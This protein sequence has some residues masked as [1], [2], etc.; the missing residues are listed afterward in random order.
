MLIA[1]DPSQLRPFCGGVFVPTMGALH[2]GH[3]SLIRRGAELANGDQRVIASIYV[4]PRQ[5][6]PH[7]DFATYPRNV[8]V[9]ADAC[10][11][12]GADVVFT[13]TT[14]TIYP[15]GDSIWEPPLPL[16]AAAPKLEDAARP[17]FF[18]GVTTVVARLLDLVKPAT[19]ILGE[20]DYQQLLVVRSMVDTHRERWPSLNVISGPTIREGDGLA[21]SS[22]NVYLDTATRPAAAAVHRALQEAMACCDPGTAEAK[23]SEVLTDAGMDVEYAVVRD[24]TT[25]LAAG[26]SATTGRCLIA[27]TLDGVRLID[28]ARW[29]ACEAP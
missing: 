13:P 20:K 12:A 6:A 4:N 3:L 1:T 23:M 28:N 15:P 2:E 7:E 19:L 26:D 22:R 11:K 5:F 16:V 14:E 25:L 24:T 17:H 10:F 18:G 27:A 9:D 29:C 8:A 21:M